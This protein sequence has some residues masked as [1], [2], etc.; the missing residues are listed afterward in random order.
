MLLLENSY[1]LLS[2]KAN[3]NQLVVSNSIAVGFL[4]MYIY[5]LLQAQDFRGEGKN[6]L[7]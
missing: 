5:I 4:R 3:D 7:Q 1:I 6:C 2:E